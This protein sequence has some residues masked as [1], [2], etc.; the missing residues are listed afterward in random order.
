MAGVASV[1]GVPGSMG[2][3]AG[4]WKARHVDMGDAARARGAH[5]WGPLPATA[6]E[7]G[8]AGDLDG[9]YVSR[10]IPLPTALMDTAPLARRQI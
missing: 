5:A 10:R 8:A 2:R 4:F 1:E 9:T 7:S 6:G 3:T